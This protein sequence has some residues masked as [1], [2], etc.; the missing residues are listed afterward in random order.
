MCIG[1]ANNF[2]DIS[3]RQGYRCAYDVT[4]V[5]LVHIVDP[6]IRAVE[7]RLDFVGARS[8][9]EFNTVIILRT[10]RAPLENR[11]GASGHE[12]YLDDRANGL[13]N[14]CQLLSSLTA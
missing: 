13:A 8:L 5:G 12:A 7:A 3:S 1:K 11:V 9:S 10:Y 14:A 4:I 2:R 6:D